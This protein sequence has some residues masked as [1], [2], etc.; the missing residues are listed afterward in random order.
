MRTLDELKAAYC[1]RLKKAPFKKGD[2][3]V[4]GKG[5]SYFDLTVVEIS[6]NT[7]FRCVGKEKICNRN[8]PD[9]GKIVDY[10]GWMF[11]DD[12]TRVDADSHFRKKYSWEDDM[13]ITETKKMI[14][15]FFSGYCGGMYNLN[16][17]YQRDLVWTKKQKE[18]LIEAIFMKK[19]TGV[20]VV[21]DAMHS[22]EH[23]HEVLDGKQRLSTIFAFMMN[24]FKYKGKTF[25]EL[26]ADDKNKFTWHSL[27]FKVMGLRGRDFTEKEKVQLFVNLNTKGT[28]VSDKFLDELR[29]KFLEEN[30]E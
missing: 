21:L 2:K 9:N 14:S 17:S 19:D 12:L 29:E 10:D 1:I 26:S 20:I 6:E 11:Y 24:E 3:L 16:P 4:V 25:S 5:I 15:I 18:E 27:S 28:R 13:N 30:N 8:N 7:F 23:S 22:S